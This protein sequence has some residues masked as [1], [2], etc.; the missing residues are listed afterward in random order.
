MAAAA[1]FEIQMQAI[2]GA[3]S[4]NPISNKFGTET[5]K[6]MLSSKFTISE[7]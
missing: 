4:G 6:S 3:I 7:V 1:T 5:Q 2:K